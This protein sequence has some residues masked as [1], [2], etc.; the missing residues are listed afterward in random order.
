[1]CIRDSPSTYLTTVGKLVDRGYA[2]KDGSSLSPTDEGRTL[3]T[4]VVPFYGSGEDSSET[5]SEGLFTPRFTALMETNLD[6]VEGGNS[7][8]ADVWHAFVGDFRAM[9]NSAL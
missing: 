4:E 7:S 9:H 5:M 6:Q 3:W 2:L 8:G 1:M